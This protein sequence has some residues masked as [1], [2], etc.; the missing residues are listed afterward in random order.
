MAGSDEADKKIKGNIGDILIEYG[1]FITQ[2]NYTVYFTVWSYILQ[3]FV[4]FT[5]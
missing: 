5:C 2:C 4:D 3:L 1:N